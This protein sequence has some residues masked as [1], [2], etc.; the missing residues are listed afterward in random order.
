MILVRVLVLDSL[1]DLEPLDSTAVLHEGD[2]EEHV[3]ILEE[4]LFET[5]DEELACLEVLSDH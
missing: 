1:P 2:F 3:G 4:A 5:H